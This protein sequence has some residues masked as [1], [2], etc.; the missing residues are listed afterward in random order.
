[1]CAKGM[2]VRVSL[3]LSFSLSLRVARSQP[4]RKLS[5]SKNFASCHVR[6]RVWVKGE[7]ELG[8]STAATSTSTAVEAGC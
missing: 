5:S 6:W 2:V 4:T 3:F 7:V 1:M 8:E